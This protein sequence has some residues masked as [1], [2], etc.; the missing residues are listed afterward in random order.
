[1]QADNFYHIY[2][3]ANGS[4][5]LF[6][7]EENY[8]Y[9]LQQFKKYIAPIAHV[10]A[11]CLIPNHF[12]FVI[13]IK[14]EKVLNNYFEEKLSK[15]SKPL[16]SL[17]SLQFSHFFNSYTQAFNKKHNRKGSLFSSNFK[18]KEITAKEYL[19]QVIVYVHLNPV[20]HQLTSNFDEF[21]YTSYKSILSNKPTLLD[22]KAVIELFDDLENFRYVHQEQK[23][24]TDLINDLILED[25]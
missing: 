6:V 19:Q 15:S 14:E 12:H 9:F 3:R 25:S 7:E 11:Y 17:L 13:K 16:E 21:P 18:R 10:Y 5:K 8:R 22:R 2:N 20:K 1:M 4:E 24:K 23:I